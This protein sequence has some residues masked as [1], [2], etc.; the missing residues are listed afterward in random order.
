[1]R[2]S[3]AAWRPTTDQG[4][5]AT[6]AITFPQGFVWGTA[7]SAYQIEG[8]V[9]EDGR[10]ES[11]WDRFCRLPGKIH[12]GDTGDVAVDHYHRWP[13]DVGIMQQLG[14]NA[15]RFSIAWPRVIPDGTGAV[16]PAELDY[17]DRLVDALLA[18]GIE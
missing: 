9:G 3:G 8:A 13:E 17:Y 6:M 18:A 7:T 12:N 14:L 2:A 10:G 5:G 4:R 1:M 16:N 15:Y 11:I